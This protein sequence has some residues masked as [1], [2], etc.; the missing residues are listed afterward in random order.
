MSGLRPPISTM[1]ARDSVLPRGGPTP[2]AS[3]SHAFLPW[4]G[5]AGEIP[6]RECSHARACGVMDERDVRVSHGR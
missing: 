1:F 4:G 5:E 3:T 6:T 2:S